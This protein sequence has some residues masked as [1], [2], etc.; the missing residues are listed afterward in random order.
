M[1]TGK[2]PRNSKD[3]V[4]D[5]E[6]WEKLTEIL[7]PLERGRKTE[8]N[9]RRKVKSAPNTTLEERSQVPAIQPSFRATADSAK[10]T[11]LDRRTQQRLTR[12]QLSAEASLD[13]HGLTA[14]EAQAKL[15]RFIEIAKTNHYRLVL[16]ITG[17]GASPFARHTL[18]GQSSYDAPE[19]SGIIRRLLP[20]WLSSPAL[21]DWINGFQPAHPRHGGGGAFYVLLKRSRRKTR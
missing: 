6:L 21:N 5:H 10:F 19:R 16:V 9:M 2:S 4:P 12:G 8:R 18:H 14:E 11:G 17:K 15:I 20:Q 1:T 7:E 3:L 13:L